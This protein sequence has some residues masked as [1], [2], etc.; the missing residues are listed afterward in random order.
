M[1]VSYWTVYHVVFLSYT[2]CL[3]RIS[4]LHIP[5]HFCVP[6]FLGSRVYHTIL[7]LARWRHF[8]AL[9]STI[10]NPMHNASFN[11]RSHTKHTS[12]RSHCMIGPF[13]SRSHGEN[14]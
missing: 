7:P 2:R 1:K 8:N 9:V 10:S 12:I 14:R 13:Y 11:A 6:L 5:L 4:V 3:S